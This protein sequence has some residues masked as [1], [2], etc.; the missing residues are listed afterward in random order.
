M[1]NIVKTTK[2]TLNLN[3]RKGRQEALKL[4]LQ[5]IDEQLKTLGVN[6]IKFK[7]NTNVNNPETPQNTVNISHI[8]DISTLIRFISYFQNIQSTRK[9]LELELKVEL[10]LAKNIQGCLVQDIIDDLKLQLLIMINK[11]KINELNSIKTKL[12]PFVDEETR[13]VETLKSIK[14]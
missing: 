10:P 14:F 9:S 7:V 4:K 2:N 1:S 13:L 3:S 12:L 6:N 8:T 11:E 5:E